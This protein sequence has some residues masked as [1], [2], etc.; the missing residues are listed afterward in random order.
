MRHVVVGSATRTAAT[1]SPVKVAIPHRR[2]T[3]EEMKAMR[4]S[5]T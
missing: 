2:G 3:A 4:I 1:K 5:S